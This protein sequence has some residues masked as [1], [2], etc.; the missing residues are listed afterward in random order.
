MK[1]STGCGNQFPS[2]NTSKNHAKNTLAR[3]VVPLAV[4]L[5][6]QTTTNGLVSSSELQLDTFLNILLCQLA[7]RT[8]ESFHYQLHH[9][10]HHH[11]LH[12]HL[13]RRHHII[14]HI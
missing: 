13:N 12:H 10:H 3:R 8:S 11:Y 1:Q 9:L 14:V 4:A 6:I 5:C 7:N 2:T